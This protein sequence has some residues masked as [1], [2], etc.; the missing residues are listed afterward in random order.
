MKKLLMTML[1]IAFS[2]ATTFAEL[3]GSRPQ[4]LPLKDIFEEMKDI[5]AIAETNGPTI[6]LEIA[7]NTPNEFMWRFAIEKLDDQVLL[8]EVAKNAPN[9]QV[10]NEAAKKLAEMKS[11]H[12]IQQDDE[13]IVLNEKGK[14]YHKT[15]PEQPLQKSTITTLLLCTAVVFLVILGGVIMWRKKQ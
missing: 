7:T 15:P 6:F 4:T 1:V 2:W 14:P 3:D 10:R 9:E 11:P 5:A 13:I 8:L 12:V